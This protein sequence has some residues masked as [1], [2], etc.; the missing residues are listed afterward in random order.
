VG[1]EWGRDLKRGRTRGGGGREARDVSASTVRRAGEWLE[2]G[3]ELTGGVRWSTGEGVWVSGVAPTG[4]THWQRERGGNG[5]A[6]AGWLAATGGA[7][8]S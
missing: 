5:R 7:H 1:S 3:R 2:S 8:G 6:S 4:E